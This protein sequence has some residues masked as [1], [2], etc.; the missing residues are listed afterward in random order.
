MN[1]AI[2]I[3]ALAAVAISLAATLFTDVKIWGLVRESYASIRTLPPARRRGVLVRLAAT[4][5][6][7]V[8]WAIV[9]ITAPFGIRRTLTYLVILPVVLSA[10]TGVIVAGVTGAR[11]QRHRRPPSGS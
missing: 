4:Y 3:F 7:A 1:V 2:G 10:L 6:V 11:G 8:G 9:V 5:I